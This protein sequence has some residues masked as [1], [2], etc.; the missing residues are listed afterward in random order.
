M[1]SKNTYI[2]HVKIKEVIDMAK[3]TEFLKTLALNLE[4]V[5]NKMAYRIQDNTNT[6]KVQFR[7]KKEGL[8]NCINC[9]ELCIHP[10]GEQH[11]MQVDEIWLGYDGDGCRWS[12]F[13]GG[14]VV[15]CNGMNA[16]NAIENIVKT[17]T[18]DHAKLFNGEF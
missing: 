1:G 5:N 17:I 2:I 16:K 9:V 7:A 14:R 3:M 15:D 13:M 4:A 11:K 10:S 8:V 6:L 12:D 18:T